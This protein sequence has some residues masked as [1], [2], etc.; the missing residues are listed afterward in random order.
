MPEAALSIRIDFPVPDFRLVESF[1]ARVSSFFRSGILGIESA[2]AAV[3]QCNT[4]SSNEQLSVF[5]SFL[6]DRFRRHS[7]STYT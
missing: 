6:P 5:R 2:L 7:T 3:Y 4:E 1:V